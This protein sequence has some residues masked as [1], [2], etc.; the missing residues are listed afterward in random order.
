MSSADDKMT[1]AKARIM[2]NHPFFAVIIA[3]MEYINAADAK[4]EKYFPTMATDGKRCWYNPAFVDKLTVNEVAAVIMHEGLHVAWLH[5]LRRGNRDPLIWNIACDYAIN[6]VIKEAGMQLPASA[7]M[8]AKYL[9]WSAYEI[10]SDIMKDVKT[11]KVRFSSAGTGSKGQ[12]DQNGQDKGDGNGDPLWGTVVDLEGEDGKPLSE[13]ERSEIE[14][15]VKI[16]V[17]QAAVTAKQRG[18]LPGSLAGL[19]EAVGKPKVNWKDYIQSWVKGKVPDNY[20]WTRPNRKWMANHGIYMPQIQMNGAGVGLLS[21][22]TSGSVSDAELVMYITEIVGV[23]EMLNPDKLIIIQHDA[24]ITK[25]DEWEAGMDFKDLHIK[26][27]SGTNI[28]PSFDYAAKMD[29][30]V[31][32]M[33]C[34]TDMGIVDYPSA[35]DAP[36]FPVL[37]CATGPD[38]APFGTYLPLREAM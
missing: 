27:R 25:V 32:W 13:A 34:F 35:K 23:I 8:E 7:L 36:E 16:M 10:Y 30:A 11:I 24:I 22:D 9:N 4:M 28:T 17:Q 15:E 14:S 20:T 1:R 19:I 6:H 38:N 3:G 37:W 21:I 33:I 29:E 18:K 5:H 31:N 12:Q 26:G 2:I